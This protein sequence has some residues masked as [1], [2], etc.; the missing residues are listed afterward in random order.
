MPIRPKKVCRPHF[1]IFLRY[2]FRTQ[3]KI[4]VLGSFCK[5]N[6]PFVQCVHQTLSLSGVFS[7][8]LAIYRMLITPAKDF[9][10]H[11]WCHRSRGSG[12]WLVSEVYICLMNIK[13]SATDKL[14]F[15]GKA[16]RV[17]V[18]NP[19]DVRF[20]PSLDRPRNTQ[21]ALLCLV[22]LDVTESIRGG[23]PELRSRP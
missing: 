12:L 10:N 7:A 2:R 4:S 23:T 21:G 19:S 13:D 16:S 5:V 14:F 15:R 3:L 6:S 18:D 22:G 1:P 20:N 11:V 8:P 17:H 9:V